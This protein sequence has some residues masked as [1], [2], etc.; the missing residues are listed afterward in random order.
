[1]KK[2]KIFVGILGIILLCILPFAC[3]TDDVEGELPSNGDAELVEIPDKA[4]GEYMLFNEVPG[5]SSEVENNEVKY[6]LDPDEVVVV[7]ELS[8]S[9]TSSNVQELMDAGLTNAE[10]K[11]TDLTGIEYFT[12]LNTLVLTSNDLE[13]LDVSELTGLDAL[14]INFNLIGN[15]DLSNNTSLTRLRY[16][17]SAQAEDDQK[18]S[19]ID[20]SNN[21][22]L[23]HLYLENQNFV[24]IDLSNNLMIDELLDMTGNPGPDGDPDTGDIIIPAAIFDQLAPEDRLGV[25]SD[26]DVM[27]TVFLAAEPSLITEDSGTA[28]ITASL[29]VAIDQPVTVNLSLSGS[30]TLDED[31][32]IDNQLINIPAGETD[33][34][35]TISAIQDSDIEGDETITVNLGN[36]DNATAGENQEVSVVI[37]DDDFNVPLILNEILYDPPGGSDGDSNGDGTRD[38]QDDEFIE[39]YND[40]DSQLDVSGFMIFDT[41]ALNSG[42]PRHTVPD[43]TII[44]PNSAFVVFGGGNPTGN[45]GGAVVQASNDI[46]NLNNSGDVLTVQDSNGATVITFDI[47]PLSDNPDESYTRNPDITGD[48]EQHADD[49]NGV[50]FTPGTKIDGS[51]F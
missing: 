19:D 36:I 46:L 23:T 28:T 40:S 1:M 14:E 29:N 41:E 25:V 45:F 17:G 11:I 27:P 31:F 13:T 6:F 4:F 2:S 38:S 20:L 3:S 32:S 18:L 10:T 39:L 21:T 9:K 30:A 7:N 33:A 15:L 26:A 8:L 37:E 44:P 35:A 5:V 42:T 51:S 22:E 16:R 34:T 43:G 47:E 49:V 12:G 48:F 50:L 24:S